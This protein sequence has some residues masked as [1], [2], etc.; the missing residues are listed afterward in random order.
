MTRDQRQLRPRQVCQPMQLSWHHLTNPSVSVAFLATIGPD[1]PLLEH[2]PNSGKGHLFERIVAIT[3]EK[4]LTKLL[5]EDVQQCPW[6][7]L[8]QQ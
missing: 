6:M 4:E 2:L 7:I 3:L 5:L 8:M 1:V